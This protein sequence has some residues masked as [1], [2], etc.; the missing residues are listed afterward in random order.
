MTLL[1][2]PVYPPNSP[3]AALQT[4]EMFL[5]ATLRLWAAPHRNPTETHPHWHQGFEAAGLE[6]TGTSAFDAFFRIGAAAARRPLDV[7]CVRCAHLGEDE[8][9]FLQLIGLLQRNRTREAEAIL[10]TWLPPTAS[11]AAMPYAVI[12]AAAMVDHRLRVPHRPDA[13]ID[14][15]DHFIAERR[16][17]PGLAVVH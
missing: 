8:A 10:A 13:S 2:R 15:N 9:W 4:A 17:A 6:D 16:P 12:V 7:R 5:V 11:R 3:I 14:D 1:P